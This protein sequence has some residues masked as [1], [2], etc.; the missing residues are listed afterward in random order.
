MAVDWLHLVQTRR[1]RPRSAASSTFDVILWREHIRSSRPTVAADRPHRRQV[2]E[3]PPLR[4]T[5]NHAEVRDQRNY[6]SFVLNVVFCVCR[7][8]QIKYGYNGAEESAWMAW[9][10]SQSQRTTTSRRE[11]PRANSLTQQWSSKSP[12]LN[13]GSHPIGTLFQTAA[14]FFVDNDLATLVVPMV[15]S[16]PEGSLATPSEPT[17]NSSSEIE[18]ERS[19][20]QSLRLSSISD[21][22]SSSK[23]SFF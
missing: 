14:R 18:W 10:T 19:F 16:K 15:E 13:V 17:T 23:D 6:E 7:E 22:W 4:L 20:H 11:G 9:A 21:W 1:R 12:S 8:W 3:R 2:G 5:R